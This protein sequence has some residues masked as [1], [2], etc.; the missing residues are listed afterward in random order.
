MA[1]AWV[2]ALAIGASLAG[3]ATH[4]ELRQLRRDQQEVR[5]LLADTQVAV[6]NL[7]RRLEA[8]RA[9]REASAS[10]RQSRAELREVV[11]RLSALEAKVE[12]LEQSRPPTAGAS[13]GA[14]AA[15]SSPGSP[16]GGATLPG[17]PQPPAAHPAA[18]STEWMLAREE[19]ALGSG[20]ADADYRE[21]FQLVRRG[22]C[23]EAIPRFREF[24]RRNPK[25]PYAD[26]AQYWIG[27]CYYAQRDYNRA[28]LEF[29]EVL[30]K[31]PKG[32]KVPAA[33]LRQAYAFGEL[34][35]KV[36]ARLILQK[37]V[38]EYP[39]S[40]EAARGREKLQTLAD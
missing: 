3:C 17:G 33:L 25:S 34:G 36:D 31:Y 32:E 14:S 19:A 1:A 9:E 11:R 12:A 29:N 18:G 7:R 22:E 26:N 39:N 20:T 23:K 2:S 37:L 27:E 15:A 30:L 35:D 28:I 8:L 16:A 5:G 4:A 38:S 10:A 40:E 13:A 24:L 6:D 21:A